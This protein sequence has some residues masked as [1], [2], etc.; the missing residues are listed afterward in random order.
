MQSVT[1]KDGQTLF[2]IAIQSLGSADRVF[3]LAQLNGLSLSD[4]LTS[5]QVLMLP[6]VDFEATETVDYFEKPWFPASGDG[7]M[8]VPGGIGYMQIGTDFKVS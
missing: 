8:V 1:V 2:D 4:E 7:E 3:D 6:D 5:G